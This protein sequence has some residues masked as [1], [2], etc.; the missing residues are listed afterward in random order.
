MTW[1]KSRLALYIGLGLWALAATLA[2][3][4]FADFDPVKWTVDIHPIDIRVVAGW[5]AATFGNGVAAVAVW[6]KWGSK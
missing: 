4:G 5:V 2:A 3:L 6:K 1:A